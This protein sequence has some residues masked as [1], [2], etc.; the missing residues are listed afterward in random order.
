MSDQGNTE[1]IGRLL[2]SASP[3]RGRAR[4][5]PMVRDIAAVLHGSL[6]GPLAAAVNDHLLACAN[7]AAEADILRQTYAGHDPAE[8]DALP[9]R[10]DRVR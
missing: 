1:W 3:W 2:E 4:G 9:D 5:H 7:C 6:S 10:E 8:R